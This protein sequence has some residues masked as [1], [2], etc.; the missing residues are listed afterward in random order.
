MQPAIFGSRIATRIHQKALSPSTAIHRQWQ[1]HLT[2]ITP[3]SAGVSI[4]TRPTSLSAT[5]P[6]APLPPS[7]SS[8][9]SGDIIPPAPL[10]WK[11]VPPFTLSLYQTLSKAKLAAFV[12]LSTMAGYALAPCASAS[13]L[14]S[15]A[16]TTVGTALCISSANALN[17]WIE[18]PY[19][20]QMARTRNRPLV[21]HALS[22]LHA[23]TF[24]VVAG[25]SGTAM[26]CATVNPLTAVLGGANIILYTCV[27]TPMKRTSM[28]N[29]WVGAIVGAI[30]PMMGWVAC[31][32]SLDPGAWLLAA[33]LYAWQF[34]HFN[35]LAWNLRPDYSKAGYRMAAV[36]DPALNAR[37]AL[38]YSLLLFP[39]AYLAPAVGMTTWW[40]VYDSTLINTML[41]VAAYRFWRHSSDKTAR[42]LFFGSLVHL[43]VFLALL[44]LHKNESEHEASKKHTPVIA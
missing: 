14:S 27:Y 21:T 28:A 38:R 31:T 24:G 25:V 3:P 8:S 40:F 18:A 43:P 9:I 44:M 1:A 11:S 10:R 13:I 23:F 22:P 32:N 29:T 4:L 41:A 33:L 20:A 5:P 16:Y 42:E 36:I 35:S 15:L 2:Y 26:L 6:P 19:D 37:V 39:I 17:Q 30:P 12:G 34:P 7:S